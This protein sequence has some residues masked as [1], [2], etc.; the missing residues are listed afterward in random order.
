MIKVILCSYNGEKYIRQQIES[1]MNQTIKDIEL[2]IFDDASTDNT[3]NIIEY[4]AQKYSG[5]I[6]MVYRA[7]PTGSS[8]RN[9]L[10]SITETSDDAD[11]YMLSDQDDIWYPEKASVLLKEAEKLSGGP[12]LIASD[13][14]VVDNNRNEVSDSFAKYS[15]YDPKRVTLGNL[16]IQN[17]LTGGSFLFNR[18][19]KELL[20]VVPAQAVMHDH[21]IAI[22]AASFGC[23][24]YI[25]RPLYDYRQ[26]QSNVVGATEGG[27]LRKACNR[28]GFS[29]RSRDEM[30]AIV[31]E[32]YRGLFNQA[33]EFLHIYG[34]DLA[35]NEK[36]VIEAFLALPES[37]TGKRLYLSV[38]YGIRYSKWY[39]TLGELLLS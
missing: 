37:G 15:G 16:L 18:E 27:F 26:H 24:K 7:Q 10:L 2:M 17:Q 4:L 3:K 14:R 31:R 9:F 13:M 19:L 33:K 12:V 25:N 6:K 28:L 29:G 8:C 20:R 1:I 22:C 5:R 21:W 34:D 11:Y 23:I 35:S 36:A 30:D 38:R 39:Q 32:N